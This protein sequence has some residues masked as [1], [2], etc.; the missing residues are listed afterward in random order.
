MVISGQ[1]I[2]VERELRKIDAQIGLRD[3]YVY[4]SRVPATPRFGIVYGS[5]AT[6]N[7]ALNKIANLSSR[8][9][10]HAQLR[11]IAGLKKEIERA[12][13]VG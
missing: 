13:T 3:V 5:Y 9:G 7:E 1:Q 2:D 11:T 6:R 12:N 4:S 10:Y 8:W